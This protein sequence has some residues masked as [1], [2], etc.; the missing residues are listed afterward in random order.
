MTKTRLDEANDA[1]LKGD[2][3]TAKDLFETL[4]ATGSKAALLG[5]AAIYERGNADI[6]RDYTKAK[7]WYER[8]LSEANSA[9]AALKLGQYYCHG[10]GVARDYRK[11]FF[12]FSKLENNQDPVAL[13][14]L[15]WLYETGKGISKDI[16][17]ARALYCRGAKLGNIQAR[18]NLGILEVK[19]GNIA[20]GLF[21]WTWAI[22]QGVPL[23]FINADDK[24]L[25]S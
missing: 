5:L 20:L 14:N 23:A 25:R 9:V 19:H 4:A 1:L 6:P 12:Y 10:R 24:R 3:A 11:A 7:F 17:R 21:L 2:F 18:K 15:G 22:I 13:L 16:Q 8:A